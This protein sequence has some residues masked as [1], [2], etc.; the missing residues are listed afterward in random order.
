MS[1]A[2]ARVSAVDAL[3]TSVRAM[4]RASLREMLPMAASSLAMSSAR[5]PVTS[6]SCASSPARRAARSGS[7]VISSVLASMRWATARP[8]ASPERNARMSSP[9]RPAMRRNRSR[10]PRE[11][12]SSM[13]AAVWRAQGATTRAYSRK[14]S[15]A[16]RGEC[17]ARTCPIRP[18]R[19]RRARSYTRSAAR[20]GP[21]CPAWALAA[22]SQDQGRSR[23]GGA[24][25]A[26]GSA[27]RL[28]PVAHFQR[29]KRGRPDRRQGRSL[30]RGFRAGNVR[31]RDG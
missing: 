12:P 30:L 8:T 9:M 10:L 29:R 16:S 31:I 18:A 4:R 3:L 26:L 20:E 5:M 22:S 23:Q 15:S 7:V 24:F 25:Q 27:I 17:V 1:I 11:T 19:P 28:R 6:P 14:I 13:L 2:L 21:K